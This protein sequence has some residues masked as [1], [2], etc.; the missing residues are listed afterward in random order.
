MNLVKLTQLAADRKSFTS[1]EKFIEFSRTFLGYV[2]QSKNIQAVI[3]SQNDNQ[4]HFYQYK[5][6][7][8]F[9]KLLYLE[10]Y[11]QSHK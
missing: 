1:L 7:I 6:S 8:Y 2:N 11:F 4:Y 3:V 5:K 9:L 10:L